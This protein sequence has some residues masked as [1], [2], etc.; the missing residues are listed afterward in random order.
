MLNYNTFYVCTAIHNGRNVAAVV[1][2]H[3]I[4][5]CD[6]I[7]LGYR[8]VN[9]IFSFSRALGANPVLLKARVGKSMW[10][11]AGWFQGQWELL[12][13]LSKT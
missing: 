9:G 8:G 13:Q 7:T 10:H 1:T 6:A 4:F 3:Q 2:K 5:Y 12:S 11:L